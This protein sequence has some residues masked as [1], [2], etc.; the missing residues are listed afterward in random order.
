MNRDLWTWVDYPHLWGTAV[1][2]A[3]IE[4]ENKTITELQM[5]ARRGEELLARERAPARERESEGRDWLPHW[6]TK[7]DWPFEHELPRRRGHG[8]FIK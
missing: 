3:D 5:R 7:E 2:A 1:A 8:W 6:P 4:P